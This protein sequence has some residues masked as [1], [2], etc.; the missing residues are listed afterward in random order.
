VLHPFER[1]PADEKTN[2]ERAIREAALDRTIEDSFPAS[3]PPSSIPDPYDPAAID[4]VG[5]ARRINLLPRAETT[6][7]GYG[8]LSAKDLKP[9]LSKV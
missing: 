4:A 7:A 9:T 2:E 8:I 6:V 1:T 3:D 5:I